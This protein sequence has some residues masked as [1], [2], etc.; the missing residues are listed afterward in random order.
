VVSEVG[1]R[2]MNGLFGEDE[3][4]EGFRYPSAFR[5]IFD[6]GLI[7]LEPW[8]LISEEELRWRFKGLKERYPKRTLLPFAI[9]T[10]GDEVACWDYLQGN[11][12]VYVINDFD[13]AG[14]EGCMEFPSFY[15]WFRH[16][17][18]DLIEFDDYPDQ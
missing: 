1:F 4:P 6:L 8:W 18:E 3:L 7:D 14:I 2:K 16:A 11:R 9:R 5:R 13:P 12:A 15:D 10:D 17:V